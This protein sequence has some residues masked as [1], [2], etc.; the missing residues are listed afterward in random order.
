MIEP[1]FPRNKLMNSQNIEFT[2]GLFHEFN[3]QSAGAI[4]VYNLKK[5]DWKDTLSMYQIYMA[6]A[7]EY[8][9]AMK[10]LGDWKHWQKLCNTSWFH[11]HIDSWREEVLIREAA[12][13]KAVVIRA[14]E[15]GNVAAAKELMKQLDKRV[16]AGRPS[17]AQKSKEAQRM[18]DVDKKVVN[19]LSRMGTSE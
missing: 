2:T 5:Y 4:P 17:K 7:S 13:G 12:L 9:A 8:E 18:S 11:P 6:C 14:A 16:G 10:L 3:L 15:E 1:L 19:L